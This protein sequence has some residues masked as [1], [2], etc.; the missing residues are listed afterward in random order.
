MCRS[1]RSRVAAMRA[2]HVAAESNLDNHASGPR[3]RSWSRDHGSQLASQVPAALGRGMGGCQYNS[4]PLIGPARGV[5]L[6]FRLPEPARETSCFRQALH[7]PNARRNELCPGQ[8]SGWST[9]SSIDNDHQGACVQEGGVMQK[10]NQGAMRA[11]HQAASS[12]RDGTRHASRADVDDVWSP[13][14]QGRARSVRSSQDVNV[15]RWLFGLP[16]MTTRRR[17]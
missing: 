9:A 12:T 15:L 1:D 16:Y 14:G 10:G 2:Y 6:R 3:A 4:A 7:S 11:I 13:L 5:W 17:P 8:R